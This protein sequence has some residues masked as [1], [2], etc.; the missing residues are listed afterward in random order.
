MVV[1]SQEE[2]AD[3]A[4][5]AEERR[6]RPGHVAG[7]FAGAGVAVDRDPSELGG[8]VSGLVP[9]FVECLRARE[10]RVGRAGRAMAQR[11]VV[12]RVGQR[13]LETAAG[14]LERGLG[15]V[16]MGARAEHREGAQP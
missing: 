16:A 2:P 7:P 11:E 15:V 6:G 3:A 14:R 5:P 9:S 10:Q 1:Q 8:D 12:E 4:E 13:V